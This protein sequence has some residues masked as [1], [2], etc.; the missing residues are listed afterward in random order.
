[1]PR[2][3]GKVKGNMDIELA[4]DAME[5][6]EHVDHFVLFSGDGDFRYLVEALQ[7][8][9]KKVTV[10]ST[11]RAQP[12]MISDELRRQA[13]HFLELASLGDRARP[14]PAANA[15]AG[16][17]AKRTSSRTISMRRT[18][19][20]DAAPP[21]GPEPPRDCPFCPRLAAFR[22]HWRERE[23]DW[24]N[25]PVPTFGAAR[26]AASDRRP[27]ARASRRQPHRAALHRRLCRRSPLRDAAQVR[28][29]RR[30][31]PG[32]PGGRA[33]DLSTLP[34]PTQSAACRRRT[35]RRPP[36]SH[37]CRQFLQ[38]TLAACRPERADP[39][40]RPHRPRERASCPR[41]PARRSSLRAWRRAQARRP[42][43]ST[44]ATTAPA[45]TR[46]PA[47]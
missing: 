3:A 14:R 30:N 36:R 38:A 37:T 28:L 26:R 16:R 25:A 9:G 41:S 44:T 10:V 47:C 27:C 32:R 40:A 19:R 18:T 13:D 39:G 12:P 31:L 7:R 29:C 11:L 34:S 15:R 42:A 4:V 6:A 45:T 23:P 2:G 22:E 1:M 35:S 43:A 5:M 8:R 20:H 24:H 21:C 46:T 33:D 17:S